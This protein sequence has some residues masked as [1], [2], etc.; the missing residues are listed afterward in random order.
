MGLGFRICAEELFIGFKVQIFRFKIRVEGSWVLQPQ[1]P[2][3]RN[4]KQRPQKKRKHTPSQTQEGTPKG[5][6][7]SGHLR[8]PVQR[9]RAWYWDALRHLNPKAVGFR[10]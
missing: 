1:G 6:T 8:G 10:V 2:A 5:Q 3:E 4:F 9:F 7:R